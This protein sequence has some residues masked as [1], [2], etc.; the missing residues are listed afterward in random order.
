MAPSGFARV[1]E[2]VSEIEDIDMP[3]FVQF[4]QSIGLYA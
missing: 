3:P 2:V 4:A 1:N